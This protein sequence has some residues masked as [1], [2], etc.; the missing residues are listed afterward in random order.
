MIL[1]PEH[2]EQDKRNA[3]LIEQELSRIIRQS[4]VTLLGEIDL[5]AKQY[6]AGANFSLRELAV[7][8][9]S[10]DSIKGAISKWTAGNCHHPAIVAI[11]SV[12]QAQNLE[13]GTVRVEAEGEEE[14][15]GILKKGLPEGSFFSKFSTNSF[16]DGHNFKHFYKL[17]LKIYKF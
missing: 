14:K 11:W 5:D 1:W 7:F 12:A 17:I 15:L 9:F 16:N 2:A 3:I 10:T 6:Y 13:D 4:Q 8:A